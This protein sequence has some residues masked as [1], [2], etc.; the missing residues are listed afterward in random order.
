L[1]K[2]LIILQARVIMP[3]TA[4]QA[5]AAVASAVAAMAVVVVAATVEVA[6]VA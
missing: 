1:A 6:A 5:V 3:E 2:L 4:R